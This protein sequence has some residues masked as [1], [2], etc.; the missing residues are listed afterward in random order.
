MQKHDESPS[1]RE[2]AY[3]ETLIDTGLYTEKNR[4]Q[5]STKHDLFL[6]ESCKTNLALNIHVNTPPQA[7]NL[8]QHTHVGTKTC[9]AMLR[10]Q[11]AAST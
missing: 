3:H 10:T 11:R 9:I 2:R 5:V 4:S 7:V 6:S 8:A 1:L